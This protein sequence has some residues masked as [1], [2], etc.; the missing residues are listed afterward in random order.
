MKIFVRLKENNRVSGFSQQNMRNPICPDDCIDATEIEL[1]SD[2]AQNFT[3]YVYDG[4]SFRLATDEENAAIDFPDED[5]WVVLR[6]DRNKLLAECDWTQAA[7]TPLTEQKK[8]EWATY[9]QALRDLPAN[10]TDPRN[11]TWPTKPS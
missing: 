2:F 4:G 9:R 11:P 7:D 1:P 8:T 10:T 6:A 5:Y 3:N